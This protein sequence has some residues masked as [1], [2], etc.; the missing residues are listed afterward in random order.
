MRVNHCRLRRRKNS[1]FV[2]CWHSESALQVWLKSDDKWQRYH[3]QKP[4]MS[5]TESKLTRMRVYYLRCYWASNIIFVITWLTY[6]SNLRKIGYNHGCYHGWTV[7]RTDGHTVADRQTVKWFYVLSNVMH[8]IRQTIMHISIYPICA[9]K[10]ISFST[11]KTCV[12]LHVLSSGLY[13]CQS[14]V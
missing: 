7:L 14:S 8:C 11:V 6:S 13:H 2:L 9:D 3:G 5:Q 10:S 4:K 12:Q 1:F